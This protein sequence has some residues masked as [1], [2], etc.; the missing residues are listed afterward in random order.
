VTRVF[1][2]CRY[3]PCPHPATSGAFVFPIDPPVGQK[4]WAFTL[5]CLMHGVQAVRKGARRLCWR[6][7][8]GDRA[9]GQL[10]HELRQHRAETRT[11]RAHRLW[12]GARA[13]LRR[14]GNRRPS[15]E[16][17]ASEAIEAAEA[18]GL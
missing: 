10:E 2:R 9:E 1:E 8:P 14:Q 15:S 12:M 11:S 5:L 7:K 17:V 6:P 16:E 3:S 13:E 4:R 18:L